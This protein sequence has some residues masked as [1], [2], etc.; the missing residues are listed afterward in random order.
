MN[1]SVI[2]NMVSE[3]KSRGFFS[4]V[5]YVANPTISSVLIDFVSDFHRRSFVLRPTSLLRHHG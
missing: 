1:T 2:H 5:H 3:P 4:T